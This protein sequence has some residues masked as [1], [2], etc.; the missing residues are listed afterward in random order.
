MASVVQGF[1]DFILRG[2]VIDLAVGV[3]VGASFK[4]IVDAFIA[5]I[6]N[7]GLGA[8]VGDQNFD[9]LA[10][11]PINYGL[12]VTALINF[13]LTAAVLYFFLVLPM[14]K[15]MERRAAAAAAAAAKI[16]ALAPPAEAAAPSTEEVLLT[17]I[18]DALRA[19][20]AR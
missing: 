12:V 13:L 4:T 8:L 7:P 15:F 20:N 5:G 17:E 3:I 1:R 14:N 18:R 9:E 19:Q 16:A 10:L 2:N 11:G 6:V